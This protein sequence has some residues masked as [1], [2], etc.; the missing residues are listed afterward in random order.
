M[1]REIPS[2]TR[3]LE[4]NDI[5]GLPV[6]TVK[7]R[8]ANLPA[9][10]AIVYTAIYVDGDGKVITPKEGLEIITQTANRPIVVDVESYIGLGAT[11]GIMMRP[12]IVGRETAD[13][14]TRVFD[15]GLGGAHSR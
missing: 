11:G 5:T 2:A 8:V 15:E 10:S 13:L 3:G 1:K 14:V 4:L 9:D 7:E 6:R 12:E